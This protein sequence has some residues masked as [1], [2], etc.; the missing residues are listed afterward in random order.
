MVT[1]RDLTINGD[2]WVVRKDLFR[3]IGAIETS[4]LAELIWLRQQQNSIKIEAT[5]EHFDEEMGL[6]AYQVRKSLEKLESDGIIIIEYLGLP[7]RRSVMIDDDKLKEILGHSAYVIG[8]K[9]YPPD[10]EQEDNEEPTESDIRPIE[11]MAKIAESCGLP[12]APVYKQLAVLNPE[13]IWTPNDLQIINRVKEMVRGRI[14][15]KRRKMGELPTASNKEAYLVIAG[16]LRSLTPFYS[17]IV[18]YN[19]KILE[20]NFNAIASE[21]R[22]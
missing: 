3:K 22:R 16:M 1:S 12:I 10:D 2:Y 11:E 19:L 21:Y 20:T 14:R 15:E 4:I 18:P 6:T 17:E 5:N 7:R 13:F 8:G 9:T